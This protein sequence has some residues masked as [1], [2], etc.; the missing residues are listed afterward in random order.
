VSADAYQGAAPPLERLL[1]GARAGAEQLIAA[2]RKATRDLSALSLNY[3][4]HS[5][6][7]GLRGADIHEIDAALNDAAT[8]LARTLF[9]LQQRLLLDV[10]TLSGLAR[11]ERVVDLEDERPV[12]ERLA[13]GLDDYVGALGPHLAGTRSTVDALAVHLGILAN[14][15]EVAACRV[16]EASSAPVEVFALIAG[17]MRALA[18]R[19]RAI[20]DDL[21]I[22]EGTQEGYVEVVRRTPLP[23]AGDAHATNTRGP[24]WAGEVA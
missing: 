20:A 24:L 4:G 16:G 3:N 8:S 19:L 10:L 23:E 7:A 18:A 13:Q 5:V 9:D 17:Q 21:A 15:T 6:R 12:A 14:N 1:A 2:L 22:F 11:I